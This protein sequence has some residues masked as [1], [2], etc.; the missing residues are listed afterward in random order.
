VIGAAFGATIRAGAPSFLT[1]VHS[2][3]LAI[4]V[5]AALALTIASQAWSAET[6]ATPTCN[7]GPQ[8]GWKSTDALK[9]QLIKQTIVVKKVTIVGDCYAVYAENHIGQPANA[10]YHPVT[11]KS[12]GPIPR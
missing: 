12:V 9:K 7:S 3:K 8:S 1:G 10:Y 6:P 11:L 4:N 2:M 5:L